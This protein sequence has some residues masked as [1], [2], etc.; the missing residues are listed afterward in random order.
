MLINA[1]VS[2]MLGVIQPNG[3]VARPAS[4]RLNEK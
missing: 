3:K 2:P 1:T 4:A